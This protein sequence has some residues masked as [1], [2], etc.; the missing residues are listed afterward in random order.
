MIYNVNRKNL[1]SSV[2]QP[3]IVHSFSL[4]QTRSHRAISQ[5]WNGENATIRV[6]QIKRKQPRDQTTTI[7]LG[8]GGLVKPPAY[9]CSMN[10]QVCGK[11][12]VVGGNP[13][14]T[15]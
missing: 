3:M 2:P 13:I 15:K 14:T 10:L 6:D 1:F 8:C 9:A 7:Y 12:L 4:D 5:H 11:K